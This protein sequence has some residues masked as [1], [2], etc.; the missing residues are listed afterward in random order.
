MF[1]LLKAIS[2]IEAL[3]QPQISQS[4]QDKP[5]SLGLREKLMKFDIVIQRVPRK[6]KSRL[7]KA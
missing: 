4:R 1:F 3:K 2:L 7:T 5:K 6:E